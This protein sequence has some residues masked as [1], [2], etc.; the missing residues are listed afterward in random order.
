MFLEFF[1]VCGLL[2]YFT[3]INGFLV[4]L[5]A[6]PL[7]IIFSV[8]VNALIGTFI[9]FAVLVCTKVADLFNGFRKKKERENFFKAKF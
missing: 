6:I 9:L 1:I 5:L 8:G 7:T 3:N 4:P 2:G